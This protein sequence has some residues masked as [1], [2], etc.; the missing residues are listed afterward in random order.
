MGT[1]GRVYP[2]LDRNKEKRDFILQARKKKGKG[3]LG[4][5][6]QDEGKLAASL[7]RRSTMDSAIVGS[8]MPYAATQHF[9]GT[10]HH[11][12]G[13]PFITTDKGTV[14]MRK[15]GKYPRGVRFTKPHDITIP[16]RPY[17]NLTAKDIEKIKKAA[18]PYLVKK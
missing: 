9:G 10:I 14:F 13:T 4:K 18:G 3:H 7:S 2:V 1:A 17:L 12:G 16:A 11:P 6:L 5:I 15:D 8:N